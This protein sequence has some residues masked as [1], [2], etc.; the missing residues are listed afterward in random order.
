[1]SKLQRLHLE[2]GQSPW[3]DNVTRPMLHEGTLARFVAIAGLSLLTAGP[4]ATPSF[5]RL[6]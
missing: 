2:Q 1:M 3:L 6:L 5:A 4:P